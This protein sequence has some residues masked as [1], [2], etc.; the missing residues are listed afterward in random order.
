LSHFKPDTEDVVRRWCTSRLDQR[1]HQ[2]K[3]VLRA[4]ALGSC[5]PPK[6]L[7]DI[8]N[9]NPATRHHKTKQGGGA[10]NVCGARSMTDAAAARFFHHGGVRSHARTP[11]VPR[12]PVP[13]NRSPVALVGVRAA[14]R[15]TPAR[16]RG[17]V[18]VRRPWR[19][20]AASGRWRARSASKE[21]E[22]LYIYFLELNVGIRCFRA[23]RI[24]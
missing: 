24:K 13:P 6:T 22:G 7:S 1:Q 2:S 20:G 11:G 21:M 19:G 3:R 4:V 16:R 18:H 17:R 15:S 5:T 23:E 12:R 8:K 14:W 10:R 9:N